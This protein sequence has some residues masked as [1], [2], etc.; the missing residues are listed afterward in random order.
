MTNQLQFFLLVLEA[1][2]A[3]IDDMIFPNV[4]VLSRNYQQMTN[5]WLFLSKDTIKNNLNGEKT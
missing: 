5:A 1:K 4:T 2:K 3:F